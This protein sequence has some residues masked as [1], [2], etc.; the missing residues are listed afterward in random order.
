[1]L[2]I[3]DS[4]TCLQFYLLIAI[5]NDIMQNINPLT[6]IIVIPIMDR[7]FYPL[8]RRI[9]V[10]MKPIRRIAIGFFFAAL[11]MAVSFD[12][13]ITHTFCVSYKLVVV[14]G[15]CTDHSI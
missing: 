6:L 5:A 13:I 2:H 4:H 3:N 15:Y 9:G 10:H 8:M 14:F 7:V 1:M 11:A 12:D